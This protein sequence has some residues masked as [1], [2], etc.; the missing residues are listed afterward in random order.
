[1]CDI[2]RENL[3]ISGSSEARSAGELIVWWIRTTAI[4]AC[5]LIHRSIAMAAEVTPS[6]RVVNFI[7][8]YEAA[9]GNS[10]KLG[11]LRPGE[12][13]PLKRTVGGW[14]V[15]DWGGVD[16]FVSIRSTTVVSEDAAG[17]DPGVAPT[18]A[19]AS[20]SASTMRAHFIDVGQGNSTLLEFSCGSV[21]ID[22]GGQNAQTSAELVAYLKA[23]FSSWD[24]NNGSPIKTIILT[25][26]HVDHTQALREVI[27]AFPS[28]EHVIENGQRGGY[29]PGD[30]DVNW[31]TQNAHTGGRNIDVRVVT[32]AN[33]TAGGNKT[34]ITNSAIDPVNCSGTDPSIRIIS[35]SQ[36]LKP[37]DE[38]DANPGWSQDE[39][40]N[41]NSHSIV[42]RVDF[43][44]ASFLFPG[45]LEESAIA[46]ML[47]YYS[48]TSLLDVDVYEVGHHGSYNG[49]TEDYI[50]AMSP[51]LA[52][53]SMSNKSDHA[54]PTAYQYGHP[55]APT[56]DMLVD[57]VTGARP[58]K[59]VDVATAV[60][61]FKKQT[62][63]KGIYGTGW[64]G[65]VTITA[66]STG[67]FS[68]ATD[69]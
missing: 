66:T 29:K 24:T 46:T 42:V 67:S 65:N 6:A 60:R 31:V 59:S 15:V 16:G 40:T 39:W 22:A 58:L 51:T 13:A 18:V 26:N 7:N 49:T 30:T 4:V 52:V 36:A 50:A 64:D 3:G 38:P 28:V 63:S 17:G 48:G 45:D 34:G 5:C 8:V 23:V 19:L 57:G 69:H 25:H 55:R 53:I 47:D 54:K 21:L 27:E 20:P 2:R 12:R 11:R 68:V 1:M 56:I 9:S 33:V 62:I 35:S 10:D 61:K 32:D 37:E 43:G 44:Q 41:K 14:R